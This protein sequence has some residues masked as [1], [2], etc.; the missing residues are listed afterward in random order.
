MRET[1]DCF[2]LANFF[3]EDNQDQIKV[4][5]VLFCPSYLHSFVDTQLKRIPFFIMT[6][7]KFY[8]ETVAVDGQ[9]NSV[10]SL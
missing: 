10:E 4:Y 7:S 9:Q 6:V 5:K 2:D 1:E 8:L 3:D